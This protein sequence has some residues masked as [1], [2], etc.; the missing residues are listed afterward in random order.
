MCDANFFIN[1]YTI[2]F[3]QQA[4]IFAAITASYLRDSIDFANKS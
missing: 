1:T 3:Q 2:L 4:N